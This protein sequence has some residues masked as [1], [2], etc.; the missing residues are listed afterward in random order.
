MLVFWVLTCANRCL[1]SVWLCERMRMSGLDEQYVDKSK[2]GVMFF[3]HFPMAFPHY[4][5]SYLSLKVQSQNL[6]KEERR[7]EIHSKDCRSSKMCSFSMQM[8]DEFTLASAVMAVMTTIGNNRVWHSSIT[9]LVS[10]GS[11]SRCVR[12]SLRPWCRT[13]FFTSLACSY[14]VA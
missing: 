1:K 2:H 5:Q 12:D 3:F 14:T 6:D 9:G 10:N 4:Y 13:T 7:G 8:R 11:A